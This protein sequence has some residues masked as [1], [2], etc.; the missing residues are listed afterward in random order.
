MGHPL[1]RRH[2][3]TL[4]GG[5]QRGIATIKTRAT[6]GIMEFRCTPA[7]PDNLLE[8]W[9]GDTLAVGL[10]QDTD[11]PVRGELIRLIGDDLQVQ[12]ERRRFQGKPGET[13]VLE[14]LNAQPACLVLVGLGEPSDF[15]GD[16]IQ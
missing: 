6:T 12:L 8:S 4:P 14:R 5:N 1:H 7:D 15:H 3:L 9:S 13:V 10:F 16:S 11:H 2:R